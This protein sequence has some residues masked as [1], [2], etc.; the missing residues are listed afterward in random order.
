MVLEATEARK[1]EHKAYVQTAAE[2]NA[3]LQLLEVAKNRLNKF[4]NPKLYK[5]APK[6]ELTE[7][8]QIYVNSGG[9][10]PRI[11]EAAAVAGQGIAGTGVTVFVQVAMRDA[12]PPPPETVD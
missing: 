12:P 10:D 9:A 4:Y 7:D 11:A 2:N 1:A 8:E 3:A 6:R 5:A